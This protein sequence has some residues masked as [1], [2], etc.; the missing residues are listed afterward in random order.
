MDRFCVAGELVESRRAYFGEEVDPGEQLGN[1]PVMRKCHAVTS[2]L[3]L[4]LNLHTDVRGLRR[5]KPISG[6]CQQLIDAGIVSL[7]VVAD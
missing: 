1:A 7:R 2:H 5:R 4:Q 3:S 6:L